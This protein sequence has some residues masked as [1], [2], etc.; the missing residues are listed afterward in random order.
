MDTQARRLTE[1]IENILY[2]FGTHRT[3]GECCEN[4]SHAEFRALRAALP[5]W[6]WQQ[7]AQ[8]RWKAE[9]IPGTV[10]VPVIGET[11]EL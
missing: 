9:A 2:H 11:F 7:E 5:D 6:K 8:K 1:L 10:R 3:D 4:I